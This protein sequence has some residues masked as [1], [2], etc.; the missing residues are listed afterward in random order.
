MFP[1]EKF[2]TDISRNTQYL[3]LFQ[4]PSDRTHI[5]I[6]DERM[7]YKNKIHFMNEKEPEK[8]FGYL[9]VESKLD[10]PENKLQVLRD[11]FGD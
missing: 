11:V 1:T 2:K 4:S 8:L 3:A 6:A 7:F 9:L 5:G 10:T